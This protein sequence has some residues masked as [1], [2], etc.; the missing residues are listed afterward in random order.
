VQSDNHR[1]K[2]FWAP[3][4]NLPPLV[5]P[6]DIWLEWLKKANLEQTHR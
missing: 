5:P 6:Q 2:L 1:F 3:V 4:D